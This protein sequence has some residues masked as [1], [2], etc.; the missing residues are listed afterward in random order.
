MKYLST[1]LLNV[2][3]ES[4]V[5]NRSPEFYR[6]LAGFGDGGIS[7]RWRAVISTVRSCK[8]FVYF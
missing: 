5:V 4:R 7:L 6:T 8:L 1:Y 2:S 3:L